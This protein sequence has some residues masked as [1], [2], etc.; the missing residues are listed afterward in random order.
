MDASKSN[1]GSNVFSSHSTRI[2]SHDI[3]SED[4]GTGCI[5]VR[6][7]KGVKR[8]G[9]PRKLRKKSPLELSSNK[10]T[11]VIGSFMPNGYKTPKRKQNLESRVSPLIHSLSATMTAAT[12]I[13][14]VAPEIN[15]PRVPMSPLLV[16]NA[17]EYQYTTSIV[18]SN[19]N[20]TEPISE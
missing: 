9:A 12:T 15:F 1:C 16:P 18:T 6:D 20:D 13:S 2:A 17:K 10:A 4:T 7:P 14:Q 11:I 8:K 3:A 19:W 5:S